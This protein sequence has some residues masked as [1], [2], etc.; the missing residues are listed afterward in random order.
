MPAVEH[1][2]FHRMQYY[3]PM[4]CHSQV[5]HDSNFQCQKEFLG[6]VQNARHAIWGYVCRV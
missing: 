4:S 3:T 2:R 5:L 6:R 1:L